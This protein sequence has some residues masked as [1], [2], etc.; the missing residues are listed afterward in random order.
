MASLASPRN[1]ASSRSARSGA[2]ARVLRAA[3]ALRVTAV[4]VGPRPS[5]RSRRSL[6]FLLPSGHQPLPGALQ[7]LG[8]QHRMQGHRHRGGQHL[9]DPP[10][11]QP[12][13][14]FAGSWADHQRPNPL[15]LM[16]QEDR[17]AGHA[18]P[19]IGPTSRLSTSRAGE[20][21]QG[22]AHRLQDPASTPLRGR[23]RSRPE[24][25]HGLDRV[26]PLPV[27]PPIDPALQAVPGRREA[28]RDD[29][30]RHQ[31][32]AQPDPF[33]QQ[34]LRQCDHRDIHPDPSG[35][36]QPID[37]VRLISRSMSYS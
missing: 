25:G 28:H 6:A 9:Q 20:A 31:A 14:L 12:E 29:R 2:V 22:L 36:Q 17:L 18:W 34:P 23:H 3:S 10:V 27:Q 37:Q 11:G 19:A 4:R 15:A 1:S 33:A 26:M 7:L 5:W 35:G 16:L 32:A 13:P 8:Q 30:G 24:P 21:A